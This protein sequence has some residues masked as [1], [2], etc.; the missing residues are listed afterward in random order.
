SHDPSWFTLGGKAK[1]RKRKRPSHGKGHIERQ[2]RRQIALNNAK[3]LL[4]PRHACR[5]AGDGESLAWAMSA[6]ISRGL[7]TAGGPARHAGST[8]GI[9]QGPHPPAA[10]G[11]L[12]PDD[13]DA[14]HLVSRRRAAHG[15]R[16]GQ[17]PRQRPA[18]AVLRRR[19]LVQFRRLR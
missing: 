18:R 5:T 4:D 3:K 19:S 10:A 15:R 7:E 11:P 8:G 17:Y 1:Q 6:Q 12:W 9:Q 13:E 14:V 2:E 16:P